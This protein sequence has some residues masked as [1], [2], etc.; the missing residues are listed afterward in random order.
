MNQELL[1]TLLQEFIRKEMGIGK[2]CD[3]VVCVTRYLDCKENMKLAQQRYSDRPDILS[4]H[5]KNLDRAALA[6][7]EVLI[8]NSI[9]SIGISDIND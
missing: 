3:V 2:V 1:K 7:E 6:L 9:E 4:W 8:D 5:Q